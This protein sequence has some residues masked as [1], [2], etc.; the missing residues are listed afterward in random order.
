MPVIRRGAGR[1]SHDPLVFVL[2]LVSAF[3]YRGDGNP[4]DLSCRS[5]QRVAAASVSHLEGLLDGGEPPY[6]IYGIFIEIKHLFYLG[7]SL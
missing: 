1:G 7:K 3:R 5:C 6:A 4:L 2:V